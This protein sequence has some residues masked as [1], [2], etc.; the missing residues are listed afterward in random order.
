MREILTVYLARGLTFR[1][2]EGRDEMEDIEVLEVPLERLYETL[3][4]LSGEGNLVDL[5]ILGLV[6]MARRQ[7][8]I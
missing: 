1:G 7:M 4:R 2:I 3:S 8:L 5:K 6:E